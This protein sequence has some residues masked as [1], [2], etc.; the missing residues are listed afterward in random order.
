MAI[1]GQSARRPVSGAHAF[2]RG[3]E[4]ITVHGRESA[5]ASARHPENRH[6]LAGRCT[7]CGEHRAVAAE[8]DHE[9]AG[10]ELS[11]PCHIALRA[12]DRRDLDHVQA[13]L[14]GPTL[15]GLERPRDLARGMDHDGHAPRLLIGPSTRRTLT[16]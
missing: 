5:E 11:S 1:A 6:V 4:L 16:H 2:Q 7:K 12:A 9:I 10:L 13:V 8:R 14:L 3:P 15:E